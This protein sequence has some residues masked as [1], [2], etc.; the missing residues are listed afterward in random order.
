MTIGRKNIVNLARANKQQSQ[1]IAD[2][3]VNLRRSLEI[4]ILMDN[5]AESITAEILASCQEDL[6]RGVPERTDFKFS[7]F[8]EQKE[9]LDVEAERR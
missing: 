3:M 8:R 9:L 1:A 7:G 5:K 4:N 6:A 2:H